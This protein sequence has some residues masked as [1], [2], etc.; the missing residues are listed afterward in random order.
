VDIIIM[1]TNTRREL[2]WNVKSTIRGAIFEDLQNMMAF[3]LNIGDLYRTPLP[4]TP[5]GRDL[6]SQRHLK[7]A[8]N[9]R[10]RAMGSRLSQE[11]EVDLR[12]SPAWF[13]ICPDMQYFL[14]TVT[15]V[16]TKLP[17]PKSLFVKHNDWIIQQNWSFGNARLHSHSACITIFLGKAYV[18]ANGA[19]GIPDDGPW[20]VAA[21]D[22]NDAD[23]AAE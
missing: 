16:R 3:M 7:A 15:K 9:E 21:V 10:Y 2:G 11:R 1:D 6:R 19:E 23:A 22:D 14:N 5:D 17:I 18:S 8:L 13:H 4:K 20:V 12:T